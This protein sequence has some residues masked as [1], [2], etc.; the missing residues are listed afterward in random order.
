MLIVLELY[1]M[2]LKLLPM[3]SSATNIIY[4]MSLLYENT[5]NIASAL[6]FCDTLYLVH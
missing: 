6:L 1:H 5:K 3:T 4:E 2:H